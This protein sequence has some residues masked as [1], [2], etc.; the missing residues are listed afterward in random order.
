MNKP[1]T[2]L[3][4]KHKDKINLFEDNERSKES[5]KKSIELNNQELERINNLTFNEITN[6]IINKKTK[7]LEKHKLLNNKL[8]SIENSIDKL[9]YYNDTIDYIIPYYEINSKNNDVKH[10][11]IIDFF[12]NSNIVKK[13]T[14]NS[15]K[16]QLLDNYLKVTENKQTRFDKSKKFKPKFCNIC[17]IEMTLHLSDG[18]LICTKCG[19]CESVILDSDKPNYKEPVPDVTAY[20]YRR[21]NHFNELT[22]S[23]FV[24]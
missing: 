7:L 23:I 2:S 8:K 19:I 12:N 3:D 13:N 21:I 15:N 16:S 18:Y 6:E 1:K 10:M 20:C 14:S 4:K 24:Y 22:K 17:N 11:E 9:I 5:I